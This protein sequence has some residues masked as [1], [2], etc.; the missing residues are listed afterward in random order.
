M[1]IP[2]LFFI[3]FTIAEVRI[4]GHLLAF[5]IQSTADLYHTWQNDCCW[6]DNASTTFCDRSGSILKSDSNP[7]SLLFQI[8]ALA[9]VCTLW[10]LLLVILLYQRSRQFTRSRMSDILC[11]SLASPLPPVG[12]IWDVML[13][14]R[15]GIL[16]ELLYWSTGTRTDR[17]WT[18]SIQNI[19]WLF[20]QGHISRSFEHCL[21]VRLVR[22]LKP[23]PQ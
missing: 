17:C 13:V 20:C 3:F 2:D 23:L 1:W 5:L 7:G 14:W 11:P 12:H 18:F 6:Q 10:V 19:S 16:T 15:K 4:F 8:L 9:E 22:K 21:P